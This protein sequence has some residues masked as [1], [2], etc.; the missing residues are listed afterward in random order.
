MKPRSR[1]K[2]AVTLL[3]LLIAITL[4]SLMVLA[5][6]SI[7]L[8]SHHHVLTANRRAQVQNEAS[9]ALE[10]MSKNI[11]RAIGNERVNGA[12]TVVDIAEVTGG[13]ER[14]RIKIYIDASGNGK[15][16][17]PVNNPPVDVDH[18][19]AYRYNNNSHP[20]LNQRNKI[21]FCDRC[22]RKLCNVCMSPGWETVSIKANQVSGLAPIKPGGSTL[23]DNFL[24]VGV[25]A[26]WDPDGTPNAC[27]TPIN[28]NV[29]MQTRI[30]MP[31]VST[32]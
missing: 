24:V 31:S 13:G 12:N 18:W 26:C 5:F 32:N 14:E 22:S 11:I 23:S 27:G 19:I 3:E 7:E 20:T 21:E 29:T 8:F 28:A 10:H 1:L 6:A 17:T 15:R 9:Y 4:F 25:T 30:K 16:E 2:N